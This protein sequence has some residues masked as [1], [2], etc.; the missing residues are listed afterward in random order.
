MTMAE[1]DMFEQAA[2]GLPDPQYVPADYDVFDRSKARTVDQFG[3]PVMSLSDTRT[4]QPGGVQVG[5]RRRIRIRTHK[6][7]HRH[8]HSRRTRVRRGRYTYRRNGRKHS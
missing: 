5:G 6:R 8:R 1:L 3:N 7:R 2:G 4:E